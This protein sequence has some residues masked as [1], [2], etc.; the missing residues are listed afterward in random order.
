MLPPAIAA[1]LGQYRFVAFDVETASSAAHSICQM[2]FA[3]VD[4]FGRIDCFSLLVNPR[5]PYAAFN[6]RLHGIDAART[7]DA[8]DFPT[9]MAGLL[10][11]MTGQP[12]VQHSTFDQGAVTAAARHYGLALPPLVWVNSVTIARRAWPEWLGQGGHGL[13]H[14]KKQLA[15]SFHH[16]DAGEDARA[17]AQVVLLAEER[18]GRPLVEPLVPKARRISAR[19][20]P[21]RDGLHSAPE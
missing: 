4:H 10:P 15:L 3:C 19:A 2:G 20:L 7:A 14:L 5:G 17:A 1:S 21:E 16:H 8:A 11:L 18:L 9:A 13:G 6:T 12:L